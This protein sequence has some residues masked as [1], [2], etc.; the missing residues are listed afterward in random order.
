M[1]TE[2]AALVNKVALKTSVGKIELSAFR[3]K[4]WD[5]VSEIAGRWLTL[6]GVNTPDGLQ[7]VFVNLFTDNPEDYTVAAVSKAMVIGAKTF[8]EDAIALLTYCGCDSEKL[9]EMPHDEF[10]SL[11]VEAVKMN[12][13]FFPKLLQSLKSV[14]KEGD[15]SSLPTS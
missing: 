12:I 15:E 13:S 8:A 9:E 2:L 1:T 3:I 6:L 11:L 4:D 7:A 14:R 5:N 10:L